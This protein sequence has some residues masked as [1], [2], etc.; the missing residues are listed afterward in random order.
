MI[1]WT[2]A[3][4]TGVDLLDEHHKAIFQWIAKLESAAA[5]RHTLLGAYAITRLKNYAEEHFDAEESLM[6]SAGYPY[7]AE[8]MAEHA[9]FRAKLRDLHIGSVGQDI[10]ADTVR[11]L[12]NWLTEHVAKADMAYLPFLKR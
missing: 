12:G 6:K 9:R 8:H 11:F 7:L 10:S 3:L 1:K 4:S 2:P 5:D